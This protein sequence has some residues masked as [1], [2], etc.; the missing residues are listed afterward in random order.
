M[1]QDIT[2]VQMLDVESVEMD[3]H[4]YKFT[5]VFQ[6]EKNIQILL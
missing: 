6:E 4:S 2:K 3:R 5:I 1:L